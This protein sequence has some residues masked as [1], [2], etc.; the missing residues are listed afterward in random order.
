MRKLLASSFLIGNCGFLTARMAIDYKIMA[1]SLSCV[2][3][4][5]DTSSNE[6]VNRV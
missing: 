4:A 6:E 5:I 1:Y 2:E 3:I